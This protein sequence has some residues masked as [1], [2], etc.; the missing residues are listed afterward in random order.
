MSIGMLFLK[1]CHLASRVAVF[2]GSTGSG[3]MYF[4]AVTHSQ[5][6]LSQDGLEMC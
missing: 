4:M 5:V 1:V 6:L 2:V 3:F